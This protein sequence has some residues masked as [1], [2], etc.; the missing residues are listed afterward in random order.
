MKQPG[1]CWKSGCFPGKRLVR[2]VEQ[3]VDVAS[4]S[5]GSDSLRGIRQWRHCCNIPGENPQMELMNE[6]SPGLRLRPSVLSVE[7][8]IRDREE[9][10]MDEDSRIRQRASRVVQVMGVRMQ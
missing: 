6:R 4:T 3:L 9:G 8:A 10:R 2:H 1:V 5:L 7:T